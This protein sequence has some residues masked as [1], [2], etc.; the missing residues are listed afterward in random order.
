[1][2]DGPE[3]PEPMTRHCAVWAN[4]THIFMSGGYD[5]SGDVHRAYLL[6][7]DTKTWTRV[8]EVPVGI[9]ISVKSKG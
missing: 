2:T 9:T 8:P 4:A 1:M 3:L 6:E 7:W 5:G